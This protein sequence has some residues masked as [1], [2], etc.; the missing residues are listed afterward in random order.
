MEQSSDALKKESS[1]A[2]SFNPY[3]RVKSPLYH[4]NCEI[5]ITNVKQQNQLQQNKFTISIDEIAG[6]KSDSG[7]NQSLNTNKFPL[8]KTPQDQIN[9][10]TMMSLDLDRPWQKRSLSV[11]CPIDFLKSDTFTSS[12]NKDNQ[13]MMLREELRQARAVEIGLPYPQKLKNI[14]SGSYY[15]QVMKKM[16]D[17]LQILQH[18]Y[19]SLQHDQRTS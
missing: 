12:F 3:K 8:P 16:K 19:T 2:D 14:H 13:I 17:E 1:T 4:Q 10:Q 5:N 18:Q 6:S 7:R 11:N 15:S 9:Q